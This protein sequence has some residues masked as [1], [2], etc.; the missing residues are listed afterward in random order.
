MNDDDLKQLSW[1]EFDQTKGKYW[2]EL[3]GV[4]RFKEAAELIEKMLGLHPKLDPV[5]ASNLH[6]HAAQCW[7][8]SGDKEHALKHLK[9]AHHPSETTGGLRWN[10]YVDGTV[11]F[12]L[13]DKNGLLKAHE[14]VAKG[15]PINQPNLAVLDRLIANFGKPYVEAY[16]T[17][18]QDHKKLSAECFNRTW[19]LLDKKERTHEEE[20][21]MISLAHASLTHWRMRDDCT[22]QNLS[23]GYW[24]I[25]RV[26]AVLGQGE[27]A[28]RYAEL[29]LAASGKEPPFYL[30]YAHEALARAAQLNKDR[31]AF[32]THLAEAKTL[33][34]KVSEADER[35]MLEDDLESLV[36]P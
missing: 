8:M 36:F 30:G 29:C 24:Q 19:E 26:Y 33:A 1:H 23:I 7:A 12:L 3:A 14:N 2:R 20:E 21:R 35:K 25:S 28:R 5:N 18:G 34:A 31:A 32:D 13:G 15:N 22:D 6:F 11:A 17:D 9:L 27:N 10:N 4:R 16:E